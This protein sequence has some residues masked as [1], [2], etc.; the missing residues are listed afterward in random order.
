VARGELSD[1]EVKINEAL[2]GVNHSAT[3]VS[4]YNELI[5]LLS[6][7]TGVPKEWIY[8]TYLSKAGNV[9]VR[10]E[11]S[12][13][14]KRARLLI[15][16]VSHLGDLG[17]ERPAVRKAAE[18]SDQGASYL[19][20]QRDDQGAWRVA[21]GL[22][23]KPAS[24]SEPPIERLAAHVSAFEIATY[25]A[26]LAQVEMPSTARHSPR[27]S[28]PLNIPLVLDDRIKRMFR[29]AVASHRAVMLIGP[30]GTGKSTLVHQMVGELA[31]DPAS[32]GMTTPHEVLTVTAD[33][34]WT[35]RELVGGDSVDDKGRLR[36]APGYV[37]QAIED[38]KWLLLDEANRADL[39]R[40]FGGLLTWLSGQEVTV[41]RLSPTKPTEIVLG[42]SESPDSS[43]PDG[44]DDEAFEADDRLLFAAG[45]EWRLIGTY[46]SVDAHRVFRLGLALG[47]RFAQVP[48]PPPNLE[49]FREIVE[50]HLDD[51][52]D[53]DDRQQLVDVLTKIYATH[54][55]VGGTALGPAPFLSIPPYV[56][57]A[58]DL[59][60][61][62]LRELIAEAYLSAFGTWLAREDEPVLDKIGAEL[63]VDEVLGAQWQ[64][65]RSHLA[66]L[67]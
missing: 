14:S 9:T 66:N 29:A 67:A 55:G 19:L 8:A 34:S 4:K 58:M 5:S 46:N 39:D 16:L 33:E 21:W 42:W 31:E 44:W 61:T 2:D 51:D 11:Q 1:L 65:V 10:L 54:G 60:S 36:F 62:D 47:R 41:G 43:S 15:G 24:L 52:W 3:S 17:S 22:Q 63:A 25:Q 45:T 50:A 37:L 7:V 35:T 12:P 53:S 18:R 48:I 49:Q 30:P 57:A 27:V 13:R 32:Y 23:P 40:I 59:E 38:D 20:L 26:P 28:L 56:R 6:Q 64:W